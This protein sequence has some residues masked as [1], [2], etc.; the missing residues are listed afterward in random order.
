[1]EWVINEDA[2]LSSDSVRL[3]RWELDS[4]KHLLNNKHVKGEDNSFV[5]L[6][7]EEKMFLQSLD[8][9]IESYRRK[10]HYVKSSDKIHELKCDIQDLNKELEDTKE[11]KLA[12]ENKIEEAKIQSGLFIKYVKD[13]FKL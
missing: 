10:D 13:K 8:I 11:S 12:L 2:A 3:C 1:M 4:L 5:R 9:L 6:T 7:K